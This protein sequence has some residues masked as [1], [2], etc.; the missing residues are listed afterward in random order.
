M[1]CSEIQVTVDTPTYANLVKFTDRFRFLSWIGHHIRRQMIFRI[2]AALQESLQAQLEDGLQQRNIPAI[3]Q[4]MLQNHEIVP[5]NDS[6]RLV[7]MLEVQIDVDQH[8]EILKNHTSQLNRL[9]LPIMSNV[10][11]M[12]E[13]EIEKIILQEIETKL[14]PQLTA[15]L[16]KNGIEATVTVEVFA[17]VDPQPMIPSITALSPPLLL[18]NWFW[19][20]AD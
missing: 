16:H 17:S 13:G 11:E 20:Q 10:P 8:H 9:I 2:A 12:V 3:I 7:I 19:S 14:A 18:L 4:V 15:E 6:I 5:Q 1:I